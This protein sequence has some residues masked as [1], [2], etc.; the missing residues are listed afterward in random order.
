MPQQQQTPSFFMPVQPPAAVPMSFNANYNINQKILD[1]ISD[2]GEYS[3]MG[4]GSYNNAPN[5]AKNTFGPGRYVGIEKIDTRAVRELFT[6]EYLQDL[7]TF[8][9]MNLTDSENL[10]ELY[11]FL[12]SFQKPQTITTMF[13]V[14]YRSKY[15][16]LFKK[17]P[18]IESYLLF[19]FMGITCNTFDKFKKILG[20]VGPA[21]NDFISVRTSH[22]SRFALIR[23]K[24]KTSSRRRRRRHHTKDG[25]A[26]GGGASG[27]GRPEKMSN[28]AKRPP[29]H[30][31]LLSTFYAQN[32]VLFNVG[33]MYKYLVPL[34]FS[35]SEAVC[36]KCL[37]R[38]YDPKNRREENGAEI[39]LRIPTLCRLVDR[40]M[41]TYTYHTVQNADALSE[42]ASRCFDRNVGQVNMSI[43][44]NQPVSPLIDI[45]ETL[46]TKDGAETSF[47]ITSTFSFY[48][49]TEDTVVGRCFSDKL[50]TLMKHDREAHTTSQPTDEDP[51]AFDE[52]EKYANAL[53][54]FD[55][56]N[57]APS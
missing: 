57:Y 33:E 2:H 47:G 5:S 8:K 52:L 42:F 48:P 14:L 23:H 38:I 12:S 37:I 9:T 18:S 43:K 49:Q 11:S 31:M 40:L 19:V 54:E 17:Y 51:G 28:A 50:F 46:P 55:K 45:M 26:S 41:T 4:G 44:I 20:A 30:P 1:A 36:T 21:V 24:R 25:G 16:G 6:E 56:R 13:L 39:R 7:N 22:M 32:T 10:D 3:T 27:G 35:I 29:V 34:D 15:P 53:A